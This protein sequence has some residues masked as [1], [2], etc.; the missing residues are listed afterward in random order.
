MA[1]SKRPKNDNELREIQRIK[2]E[3][4]KLR[5]QVASLRKQLSRVDIE[6]YQN[7]RELLEA[8]D[9]EDEALVQRNTLEDMKKKW[10]CFECGTGVLNLV[11]ISKAGTPHYFRKCDNCDKRT[12]L[13]KYKEDIAGT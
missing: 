2:L 8:H 7:V 11:L 3:N 12:K 6:Q 4:S 1:R 5:K 13:K 10:E 9:R